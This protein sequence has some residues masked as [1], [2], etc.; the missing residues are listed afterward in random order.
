[1]MKM[2]YSLCIAINLI[3]LSLSASHTDYKSLSGPSTSSSGTSYVECGGAFA[4]Q[5]TLFITTSNHVYCTGSNSCANITGSSSSFIQTTGATMRIACLASNSCYGSHLKTAGGAIQCYGDQS[6]AESNIEGSG[7]VYGTGAY[8]LVNSVIMS[9]GTNTTM[10]VDLFGYNA[11]FG[12]NI[13]CD[14]GDLCHINCY[15]NG[16]YMTYIDCKDKAN[17]SNCIINTESN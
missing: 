11:G 2:Y 17:G 13:S 3:S 4:C 14:Y 5:S 8:S 16:C 15:G 1:M 12:A 7:Y 10:H 6:C 9:P